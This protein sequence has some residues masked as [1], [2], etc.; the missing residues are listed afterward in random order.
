MWPWRE[1]KNQEMKNVKRD[2]R[3]DCSQWPF[4]VSEFKNAQL[5]D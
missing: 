3:C 4:D 1:N 5:K 2:M